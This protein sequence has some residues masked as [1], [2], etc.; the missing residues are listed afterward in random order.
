MESELKTGADDP[1]PEVTRWEPPPGA[2]LRRDRRRPLPPVVNLV[3]FLLTIYTTLVAG[4]LLTIEDYSPSTLWEIARRPSF[5]GLGIPYSL[6]LILILGT[7]EMGHYIACRL[8]RIDASLPFFLP[9]PFLAGTFGAVI[10]IRAPI[11]DR[12]ALF[13]IGVAG[14]LAGFAVAIPVLLYGLS[15]SSVVHQ[16][17]RPGD[18]GLGSCLLLEFLYPIFFRGGADLSIRLHPTFMAGWIGLLATF[19][20]LLPIGQLDGGHMVYALS[21]RLHRAVSRYGCPLLV[22]LGMLIQG[23]HL[24]TFG[25]LFWILGPTHPPVLDESQGLGPGRRLIA[26]LALVIFLVCFIPV[27][28][29]V[30]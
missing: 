6:S 12:R 2:P 26:L 19:L 29:N 30:Y 16:A 25:I 14:P 9:S 15:L 27:P 7:H 5:W 3:C 13:D 8:Y 1:R 20:N 4:T 10:R 22:L 18:I 11:T 24:V 23:Y 21:R 17:P 28:L